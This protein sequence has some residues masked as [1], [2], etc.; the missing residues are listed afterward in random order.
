MFRDFSTV[1][2]TL[3]VLAAPVAVM[4]APN[5]AQA[6][7]ADPEWCSRDAPGLYRKLRRDAGESKVVCPDLEPAINLPKRLVLSLPCDRKISFARVDVR[8]KSVLDSEKIQLG[9][10]PGGGGLSGSKE[11]LRDAT[12]S[13]TF[14]LAGDTRLLGYKNLDARAYYIAEYELTQLQYDL[15]A[16][17]VDDPMAGKEIFL[18]SKFS[19]AEV[20]NAKTEASLCKSHRDQ[21]NEV[22]FKDILPKVKL[23]KFEVDSAIRNLNL[24]LIAE[25]RRQGDQDLLQP[26]PWEQGSIGFVRLPTEAEWEYASRGGAKAENDASQVYFGLNGEVFKRVP[27]ERV[28]V[29][30]DEQS[31]SVIRA[32]GTKLPNQLGIYDMIG[33]AEELVLDLFQMTG[34]PGDDGLVLQGASGG[35]VLRGGSAITT[36][37]RLSH[38]YRQELPQ[39]TRNQGEAKAPYMGV[40]LLI[41]APLFTHGTKDANRFSENL[42]NTELY[43]AIDAAYKS[44][45]APQRGTAGATARTKAFGLIADMRDES[46]TDT[47]AAQLEQLKVALERSE[48][49]INQARSAE[50]RSTARAAAMGIMNAHANST[51]TV[52][53]Y[54]A[55]YRAFETLA[56]VPIGSSDFARLKD[57]LAKMQDAIDVRIDLIGFQTR[58]VLGLVRDLTQADPAFAVPAIQAVKEELRS[59]GLFVYDQRAWPIFDKAYATLRQDPSR[60]VFREFVDLIDTR[61]AVRE[62]RRRRELDE[63]PNLTR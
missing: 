35:F 22:G 2:T 7:T 59:Q 11:G 63:F 4:V 57:R 13:G 43:D 41:S 5:A 55:R 50:L 49:Q 45:S 20:P 31:R 56:Q 30:S 9:G 18:L 6:Q 40:R 36:P 8:V 39:Y 42:S 32:V 10:A 19:D 21:A 23:T 24:Y 60:D 62:S 54:A 38:S 61:R 14:S 27:L 28:A 3:L 44:E 1:L 34:H 29:V 26:V 47:L 15:L 53:V 51:L 46:D 48:R 12:I 33:N 25:S 58:V 52:S 16:G 37:A 17:K